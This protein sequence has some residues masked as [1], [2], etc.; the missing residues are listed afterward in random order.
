MKF[1][2]RY[3]I[4]VYALLSVLCL[5]SSSEISSWIFQFGPYVHAVLGPL[6]WLLWGFDALPFFLGATLVLLGAVA[7][8]ALLSA[9]FQ[10]RAASQIALLFIVLIWLGSGALAWAPWP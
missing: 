7:A 6:A 10:S 8:V 3:A 2:F 5:I 9:R 4:C 1:S